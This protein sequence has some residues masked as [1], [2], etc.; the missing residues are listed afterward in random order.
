[1][2]TVN[3]EQTLSSCEIFKLLQPGEIR[4]IA[5]I[6]QIKTYDTGEFVYQQGDFGEYLYIIADGQVVLERSMKIGLREGK[7]VIATIGKGRVFGCWSI[8]LGEPHIMM[9]TTYCQTPAKILVLKCAELRDLMKQDTN[10]GFNVME[11]L[12]FLLRERIQ[13][14]YGAMD[15][16]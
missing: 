8:L 3:I 5:N 10:F 12:C 15:R 2:K 4:I 16:I 1:M 6:C 14:A 13:A 7:V 9:L 11:R